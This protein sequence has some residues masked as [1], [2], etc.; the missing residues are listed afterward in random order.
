MRARQSFSKMLVLAGYF[1]SAHLGVSDI[2]SALEEAYGAGVYV[3]PEGPLNIMRGHCCV[4][5]GM[6]AKQRKY[7]APMRLGYSCAGDAGKDGCS[8]ARNARGDEVRE[9][10]A[11]SGAMTYLSEH[12]GV[13]KSMFTV[14]NDVVVVDKSPEAPFWNLFTSEREKCQ[15]LFAAL[16]LLA[17]GADI[18]LESGIL[19]AYDTATSSHEDVLDLQSADGATLEAVKFFA[20]YGGSNA[21]QVAGYGLHYTDSPS[22]LIQAYICEFVKGM[23][24]L[25]R[26]YTAAKE[27]AVE[28]PA[29][30]SCLQ[31]VERFFTTD[32]DCVKVYTERYK[33]LAEA[34]GCF[35]GAQRGL[36]T[37]WQNFNRSDFCGKD[38]SNCIVSALLK[39]CYCLA[40]NPVANNRHDKFSRY[41]G[42]E[43][44]RVFTGFCCNAFGASNAL[45]QARINTTG[46]WGDADAGSGYDELL[47]M[48]KASASKTINDCFDG[49]TANGLVTDPKNFLVVLAWALGG[50]E[51]EL[52]SLQQQLNDALGDAGSAY[53][54]QLISDRVTKQLRQI[55]EDLSKAQFSVYKAPDG[56]R[57]GVLVFAFQLDC[58][59]AE[60]VYVVKL[61][62]KPEKVEVLYMAQ[63]SL[64]R[65]RVRLQ[66]TA[67]IQE[68][69]RPSDPALPTSAHEAPLR[70]LIRASIEQ[71][72]NSAAHQARGDRYIEEMYAAKDPLVWHVAISHW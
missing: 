61:I 20:K 65:S 14:E 48:A 29:D 47:A 62:F 50:S 32:E 42:S 27:I 12:Y 66:L 25:I 51:E 58:V 19:V 18:R 60:Y 13:L 70:A 28:L 23:D 59:G 69:D 16:L 63:Q 17:G 15:R 72:L 31:P 30:G 21:G 71:C 9:L 57:Y 67:A 37:H 26:I 68:L 2:A 43:L 3:N 53:Y 35:N 10:P 36:L 41:T 22:F 56:A 45:N 55:S 34:E 5:N 52:Q 1:V 11:D 54:C 6:I 7:A 38:D 4:N 44:R 40:S 24:I 64:P 33:A 46:V 49:N 39:L 8:Y